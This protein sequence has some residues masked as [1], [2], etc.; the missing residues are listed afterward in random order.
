MSSLRR[1]LISLFILAILGGWLLAVAVGSDYN[2]SAV[3]LLGVLWLLAAF[4]LSW[5]PRRRWPQIALLLVVALAMLIT[6]GLAWK[7]G[8]YRTQVRQVIAE[9]VLTETARAM[10]RLTQTGQALPACE[11]VRLIQHLQDTDAW[12]GLTI[13]YQGSEQTVHF[14][15]IP[16]NDGWGC[17][18]Q[19]RL[20]APDRFRL[21]SSGPDRRFETADDIEIVSGEPL[22]AAVRPLP[23]FGRRP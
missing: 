19:Y 9:N 16:R 20:E 5:N 17:R 12:R 8:S 13:P 2:E 15:A 18:Y 23:V 10:Q 6:G 1:I 7:A 22:P 14:A 3:L 21:R 11:W 4:T